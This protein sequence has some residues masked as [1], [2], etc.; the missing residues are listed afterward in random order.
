MYTPV[1]RGVR[2]AKERGTN[3]PDLQFGPRIAFKCKPL[4]LAMSAPRILC[5]VKRPY[6]VAVETRCSILK[7]AG[8]DARAAWLGEAQ[9]LL[10]GQTFDLVILS[11]LLSDEEIGQIATAAGSKTQIMILSGFVWP[12]ALL[13]EVAERLRSSRESPP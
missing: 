11:A 10:R 7:N 9:T 13:A 3:T 2:L 5:V 1:N 4:L 12:S 6:H 8:Y